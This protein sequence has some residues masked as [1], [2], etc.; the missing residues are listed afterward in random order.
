MYLKSKFPKVSD[1]KLK[2]GIFVG[3]QIRSLMAD[4]HFEGLLNPL[5]KQPE[6]L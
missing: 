1:A 5:E 2:E 4:E 6:S 3:L